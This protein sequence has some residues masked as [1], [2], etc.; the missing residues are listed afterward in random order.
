VI[1]PELAL[2]RIAVA[3]APMHLDALDQVTECCFAFDF[4]AFGHTAAA[5]EMAVRECRGVLADCG[6]WPPP[7]H[8]YAAA[9]LAMD[10]ACKETERL[11]ARRR[12]LKEPSAGL[13]ASTPL[14]RWFLR[15]AR[16]FTPKR[17]A[18]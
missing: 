2:R 10:S 6:Y 9:T 15:V 11:H 17:S 13:L 3:M 12:R 14:R 8:V 1:D 18:V 4:D 5:A 7:E 16:V